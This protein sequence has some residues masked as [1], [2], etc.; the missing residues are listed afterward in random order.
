MQ[1]FNIY[2]KTLTG[3]TFTIEISPESTI[4]ELK[5]ALCDQ[6]GIPP[7]QQ[8]LIFAGRQLDETKTIADYNILK[9]STLH[10]VL[11]LRGGGG[12]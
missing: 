7:E 3:K 2:I 12:L 6:E 1:K 5:E 9:L 4:D 10:L 8:R 11:R